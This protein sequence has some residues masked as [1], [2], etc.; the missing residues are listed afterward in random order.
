[1]PGERKVK[2][3]LVCVR[4]L[5]LGYQEIEMNMVPPWSNKEANAARVDI[6]AARAA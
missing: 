2:K 3:N 6:C 1:M 5:A 4:P